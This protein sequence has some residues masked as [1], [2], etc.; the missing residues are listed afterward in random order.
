LRTGG[1]YEKVMKKDSRRR[2][3][4]LSDYDYSSSGAYF[5]TICTD[6]KTCLFGNIVN[7][8]IELNVLGSIVQRVWLEIPLHFSHVTLCDFVVMPNHIHGIIHLNHVVGEN[9]VVRATH[10][11]PLQGNGFAKGKLASGS[12]GAIVGSFKS[13]ASKLLKKFHS[14]SSKSIWQRN[15]YEHVI[16]NKP[17][18]ERISRLLKNSFLKNP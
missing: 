5:V 4:R 3:I 7:G 11:S 1:L 2:I 18:L 15:Y 12:L 17:S 9:H 10:A 13:V 6:N 16:R 14:Y 8:T